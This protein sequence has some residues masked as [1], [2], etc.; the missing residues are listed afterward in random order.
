MSD[1]SG[2]EHSDKEEVIHNK[3]EVNKKKTNNS[4]NNYNWEKITHFSV[5]SSSCR[6]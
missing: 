5:I 6:N 3:K 1:M 4:N 2:N